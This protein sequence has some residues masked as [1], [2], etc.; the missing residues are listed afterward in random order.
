MSVVVGDFANLC[1]CF[2]LLHI[3][4]SG[5]M[6]KLEMTNTEIHEIRTAYANA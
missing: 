6:A 3:S 2:F 4:K 5:C 1:C